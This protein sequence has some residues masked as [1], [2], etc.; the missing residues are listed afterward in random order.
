MGLANPAEIYVL[1]TEN[2]TKVVLYSTCQS[3]SFGRRQNEVVRIFTSN[4]V[5]YRRSLLAGLFR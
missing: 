2:T 5:V 1:T 4:R 3:G